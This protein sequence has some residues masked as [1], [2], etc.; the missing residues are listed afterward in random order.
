MAD[1]FLSYKSEDRELVRPLAEALVRAGVSVWWDQKIAAGGTWRETIASALNDA[2][3]VIAVWSRRTEDSAAAAWVLNE[4]D[5]A[6]RMRRPIIPIQIEPCAIPLGYRHVQCADLS[7]WRGDPNHPEWREVLD[8]VHAALAGKR[9]GGAVPNRSGR[10]PAPRRGAG[11]MLFAAAGLAAVLGVIAYFT[12]IGAADRSAEPLSE[13]EALPQ[14]EA[15]AEAPPQEEA[16]A[17]APPG[18]EA[19]AAAPPQEEAGAEAPPQE[20]AEAEAPQEQSEVEAP[21]QE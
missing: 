14:E 3:V 10:P 5:E 2:K 16:G 1:V 15:G 9:I 7:Q 20:G 12:F 21:A 17:E 19:G 6:Q 18:E 4:V 11:G 13:A 8:G